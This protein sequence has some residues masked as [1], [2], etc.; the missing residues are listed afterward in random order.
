MINERY[1]RFAINPKLFS[2]AKNIL[3]KLGTNFTVAPYEL[4]TVYVDEVQATNIEN[5]FR[6][7]QIDYR[8]KEN[9]MEIKVTKDVRIGKHILE[10]GDT[11]RVLEDSETLTELIKWKWSVKV[12]IKEN[13]GKIHLLGKEAQSLV[14]AHLDRNFDYLNAWTVF[15]A[16]DDAALSRLT[17]L[18]KKYGFRHRIGPRDKNWYNIPDYRTG[19]YDPD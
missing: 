19:D 11:I 1:K 10:A 6:Y 15:I 7:S 16:K 3:T 17:A 8:I 13:S 2:K 4:N 18:L 5:E 14:D 9:T 12:Y